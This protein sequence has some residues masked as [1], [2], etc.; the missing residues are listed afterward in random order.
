MTTTYPSLYRFTAE[1]IRLFERVMTGQL[2]ETAIELDNPLYVQAVE[3][4]KSLEVRSF[5]TAKDMAST[6]CTSFASKSPQALAGDI[7]LWSWLT[8][9]FLDNLFPKVGDIRQVKELHR[10]YPAAPNDWQKAQRHL[11]RMPVLLL[12][13]FGQDADHLI[14]GRPSVGPDI[15]EQLTSQQDMFSLNFQ[16]ACRV[17]YFDDEQGTTKRGAGSKDGPGIPRRLAV[18]RRQLDVT[19]DM[20]D[21]SAD[22]ILQL[23]PA[24]FDRYKPAI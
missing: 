9:V 11:V 19:W 22:R 4:T 3:G 17:L 2:S 18:L 10:W 20:T 13:A 12:N 7:G 24:E 15:R 6:V 23:L 5:S 1:G 14:C 16:K 8:F 21:L